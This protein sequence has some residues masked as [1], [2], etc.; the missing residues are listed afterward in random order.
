[1]SR[2]SPVYILKVLTND[3][4]SREWLEKKTCWAFLALHHLGTFKTSLSQLGLA[5]SCSSQAKLLLA[6]VS[7]TSDLFSTRALTP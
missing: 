3:I 7:P 5:A 4:C 2:F 6:I 1:M